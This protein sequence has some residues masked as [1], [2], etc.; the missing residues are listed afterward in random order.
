MADAKTRKRRLRERRQQA[1][2]KAELVWL[3]PAGCA[4]MAAL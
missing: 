3:T 4:A 2:M 1:G